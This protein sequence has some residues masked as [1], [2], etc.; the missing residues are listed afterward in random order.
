MELQ[1]IDDTDRRTGSYGCALFDVEME[2][3]PRRFRRDD[4][5]GS[6]ECSLCIEFRF[7]VA[8]YGERRRDDI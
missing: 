6:L 8:R 4:H 5:F 2:Y 3:S 7:R 1:A